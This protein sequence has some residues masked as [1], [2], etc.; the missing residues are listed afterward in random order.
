MYEEATY[1]AKRAMVN[2]DRIIRLLN[3]VKDILIKKSIKSIKIN[4]DKTEIDNDILV[5]LC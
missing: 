1:K 2:K 3:C 5:K 4:C